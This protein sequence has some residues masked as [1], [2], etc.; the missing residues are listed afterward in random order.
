MTNKLQW[1]TVHALYWATKVPGNTGIRECKSLLSGRVFQMVLIDISLATWDFLAHLGGGFRKVKPGIS[2]KWF[3][4]DWLSQGGT[5]KFLQ[6]TL[7]G[8]R[9]RTFFLQRWAHTACA[10]GEEI[11]KLIWSN[12]YKVS[13]ADT[14][15]DSIAYVFWIILGFCLNYSIMI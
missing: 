12:K 7:H 5:C 10:T 9:C 6:Q 13:I 11:L 2:C 15:A 14:N 4:V 3:Y 1:A 8:E